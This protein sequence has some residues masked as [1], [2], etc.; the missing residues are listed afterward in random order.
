MRFSMPPLTALRI[1][2]LVLFALAAASCS[3]DEKIGDDT[4]SPADS[5]DAVEDGGFTAPQ[6]TGNDDDDSSDETAGSDETDGIDTTESGDTTDGV[7]TTDT[8]TPE[9][10]EA[11][12][13]VPCDDDTDCQDGLTCLTESD[14][15]T[16]PRGGICTSP[17]SDN[18]GCWDYDTFSLCVALG[19]SEGSDMYC[20]QACTFGA[21]YADKCFDS[22]VQTCYPVS[23][24]PLEDGTFIGACYPQ[25]RN[26]DDCASGTFCDTASGLCLEEELPGKAVGEIC[27]VSAGEG[28]CGQG[29]ACMGIAE[30]ITTGFCTSVCNFHPETIICGSE[31]VGPDAQAAC[32][33]NLQILDALGV[34]SSVNDVG[35]CLPLC[36]VDDDC[37]TGMV[38]DVSD[39]ELIDVVGRAG[40]CWFDQAAIDDA[41]A[42]PDGTS[43]ADAATSDEQ[44]TS[45]DVQTTADE[46]ATDSIP[47]GD[48][49][50]AG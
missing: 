39:P 7:D 25:C 9:L 32:I 4:S 33:P 29:G 1:S 38:C 17:C 23:N 42:G 37:P 41:L 34:P 8:S 31:S 50:D 36:D 27:D 2:S 45:D 28:E 26:D 43:G 44:S 21:S 22:A 18:Q 46:T 12:I 19:V 24:E 47:V 48:A 13:G 15:G 5:D 35:Q 6:T 3:G 10:P 14:S 49:G 30:G 16:L 40:M 20:V 11:V